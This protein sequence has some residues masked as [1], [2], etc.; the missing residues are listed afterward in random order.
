MPEKNIQKQSV[1]VLIP[2]YNEAI[3]IASVITDFSHALP[4]AS[5]Y[6]YDNNSSDNT[7]EQARLAGAVVRH[8]ALQGKGNV[9][10]RMFADIDADIY[11]LVDGDG[12]YE[13]A[14]A[15]GMIALLQEQN[16]DMVVGCR[17]DQSPQAYRAGHRLGNMLFTRSVALLFGQ[18][19]TDILSGYRVFS[20][21]FVLSFPAHSAGFEIE[22]E[23]TV[24]SLQ[25]RLRTAELD[26]PYYSRA[27]G[28]TSKLNT[29]R[30]GYRIARVILG[31]VLSE[32][33]L[34]LLGAVATVCFAAS[35]LLFAPVLYT[36][37]ELGTVPRF[38]SL[39]VATGLGG[40]SLI[41]LF[42]GY[43]FDRLSQTRREIRRLF[44]LAAKK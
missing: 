21:P 28:S 38:P 12:T 25:M 1:A 2:C 43:L 40:F 27:E 10:R 18:S 8:E 16:C 24:H 15:P 13:A 7:A 39:I 36:Y 35:C 23:L 5:I 20:R 29:W 44:Y 34:L 33:P 26:T 32:R 11:V 14:S 37:W 41:T 3:S 19:F 9:V 30:D 31:L 6:V 42:F 4:E 17:K 22:T